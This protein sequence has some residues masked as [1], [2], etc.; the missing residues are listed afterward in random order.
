[1]RLPDAALRFVVGAI[2]N[3][4]I[5]ST[6]LTVWRKSIICFWRC[7][8]CCWSIIQNEYCLLNSGSFSKQYLL[9][10]KATRTFV[11]LRTIE[12]WTESRPLQRT[13]YCTTLTRRRRRA[14]SSFFS[15][16]AR[17]YWAVVTVAVAGPPHSPHPPHSSSNQASVQC[18]LQYGQS[19]SLRNSTLQLIV[20][21]H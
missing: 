14:I 8:I 19:S 16:V 7:S 2:V 5:R 13:K 3:D 18:F 6:E 11:K 9:W 1:M 10:L 21:R 12:V 20:P 17:D 15:P 4:R